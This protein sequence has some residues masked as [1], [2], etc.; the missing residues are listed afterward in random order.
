[1]LA[2]RSITVSK[3]VK[4]Y[5]NW[6]IR[7]VDEQGGRRSEVHG[8]R[9]E[10]A[11]ALQRHELETEERRRGLRPAAVEP[12]SFREA[13]EYWETHRAPQKRSRRDDISMLKQLR[14]AFGDA[15]LAD[16]A[17]WIRLIDRDIAAKSH[18][19][20]KTVANHLT[21][22]GSVLRL[23]VELEWM[24][25]M[26]R[27]RKPKVRLI[28]RDYSYLRTDEEIARF[29]RAAKVE[30]LEVHAL[31]A[32]AIYTGMRAG[33]IAGLLWPDVDLDRRLITVQ[34]SFD[35]PTKA[36]DVRY[37]PIVDALLPILREWRLRHPGRLVFTNRDGAMHG[38][39]GRIFQEVL[40]RVI[41]RAGLP[42]V[43][44]GGKLVR[45]IHFHDL[46]HTFASHWVM[47][48]GDL[49][50]LQK[51]LGHKTVQMTLRYAHLQPAAFREDYGRF[52]ANETVG[53]EVVP[54][55]RRIA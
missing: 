49:F 31:Y 43:E 45:Y 36:D 55:A 24:P 53:A 28:S 25:K 2:T 6:R 8:D 47:K 11:L 38:K 35:G 51:I 39:S 26:P 16:A 3:P 10:A 23:A 15:L 9:K 52:A 13:A 7:W 1:V 22:L 37:V 4:H 17:A 42:D 18:L 5:G 40:H 48:G 33:E 54:L 50:K 20:K 34:R 44:R 30:G 46:R 19:N 32:T 14:A 27:I 12:K 21:L 41:K 29:L